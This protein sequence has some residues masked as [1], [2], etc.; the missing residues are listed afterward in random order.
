VQQL[1]DEH[2]NA[3]LDEAVRTL[4]THGA[5]N[6]PGYENLYVE[7][8]R[9]VLGRNL[10][11]ET[12]VGIQVHQATVASLRKV[13]FSVK[14][15]A[16]EG[17]LMACHY[18]NLAFVC[19]ALGGKDILELRAK[20]FISLLR[21]PQIIPVDKAFYQAGDAC[22]RQG[23]TSLAFVLLNRYVDLTEAIEEGEANMLDNSDF[24]NA[25][26]V[27]FLNSLPSQQY[28]PEEV[29]TNYLLYKMQI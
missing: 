9:Q 19:Q 29:C 26:A 20:I 5:P 23:H 22:K 16:I 11:Q 14:G 17:A 18:V 4:E 25:T 28:L 12:A 27:T 3:S 13:L 8:T 6:T 24:A 2:N 7:L 1:L 10:S 15:L 21:Y